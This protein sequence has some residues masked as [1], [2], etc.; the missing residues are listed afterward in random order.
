[1]TPEL[2]SQMCS[3]ALVL[4]ELMFKKLIT[5]RVVCNLSKSHV[6]MRFRLCASLSS[7][8]GRGP[9]QVLLSAPDGILVYL[10]YRPTFFS[11]SD[12]API[13][14]FQSPRF[15]SLW[16]MLKHSTHRSTQQTEHAMI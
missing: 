8:I 13:L 6:M 12:I 14:S 3:M 9:N 11:R 1:M 4:I 7:R 5:R 16:N 10:V 15:A 2:T